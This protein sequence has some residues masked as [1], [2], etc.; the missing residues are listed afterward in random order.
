MFGKN[1]KKGER[2]QGDQRRLSEIKS[3]TRALV[4]IAS[5]G[6][7]NV[8]DFKRLSGGDPMPVLAIRRAQQALIKCI[9]SAAFSGLN[10]DEIRTEGIEAVILSD[11]VVMGDVAHFAMVEVGTTIN[12]LVTR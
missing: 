8:T 6:G 1:D 2:S 9:R 10:S 5:Q 3:L 4:Q 7:C 11:T 12:D